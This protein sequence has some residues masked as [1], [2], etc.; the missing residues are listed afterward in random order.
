MSGTLTARRILASCS[1]FSLI[2]AVLIVFPTTSHAAVSDPQPRAEDMVTADALPTVQID[3]IAWAQALVGKT[4]YAG[5]SFANARPAG[6]AP[7]TSLTP[8]AN[9]LSYDLETGLLRT[10]FAPSLNGQVLAVTASPDGSRIYVGGDFTQANGQTRQRIAA[11]ST[12]TGELISSFAPPVNYQVRAI[13]ATDSVVYVGGAFEGVGNQPRRN[14]AAFD[15]ATGALLDWAPQ[16]DRTVWGLALSGDGQTLVASGQF[17]TVNGAAARGLAKID[18]TNGTLQEWPVVISNGGGDAGVT[19][20]SIVDDWVYGTTYHFGPGGNLEGPFKV[21]LTTGETAWVVDCHGDT[22]SQF[23]AENAFYFVGHPH[24]CG[25]V[26]MGFPQYPSWKWQHAMAVSLDATGETLR[27]TLGYHNW[28]GTPSPSIIHWFPTMAAGNKSGASQAAWSVTGND[29]YIVMGGEFPRVNRSPQEGLVRFAVASIAP[30]E[31]APS[32]PDGTLVPSFTPV[33]AG[34]INVSWM[35]GFDPDDR[36]L[37]Y[38][39]VRTPGGTVADFEATSNWWQVPGLNYVDRNLTPGQTYSYQIRVTDGSGNRIFGSTRQIT[40][41][42]Y[43]RNAYSTAVLSHGP[44]LYWPMNEP[45]GSSGV[46]DFAGGS[47]GAVG[48]ATVLGVPGAVSGATAARFANSPGSRIGSAGAVES[49]VDYSVEAWFSS[50]AS[51]GPILGFGDLRTGSSNRVDRQLYLNNGGRVHFG[52]QSNGAKVLATGKP[53]NDGQWHHVVGT[54]SGSTARLYV[55]GVLA[56]KR[57]DIV[58]PEGFVGHWRVG[59]DR[60]SS[61]PSAGAADFSGLIDEV[62]VYE[63]ALTGDEVEQHFVASGRTSNRPARPDDDYGRAVYDLEPVLHWRLGETSGATVLDSGPMANVGTYRG[64]YTLSQPGVSGGD[65]GAVTFDGTT[66]YAASNSSFVNPQVFST[67][68]WFKTTTRRGGKIIGFGNQSTSLS[69]DY[70]RHVYMQNDGRL[71]FGVWPGSEQRITTQRALNDGEWHHLVATLSSDGMK[72]YVDGELAGSN[73]NTGA[74]NYTG[75]WRIGGDR[76]WGGADSGFFSGAIDEVT[77]YA[78]ALA[79]D[80]VREHYL[81]GAQL[82]PPTAAFTVETTDLTVTVDGSSSSDPDGSVS[83]YV[84]DFGDGSTGSGPTAEHTYA[85]AGSYTLRL[86]VTDD[87]GA[88]AMA[89]QEVT[90]THN[91]SPI[92][93]FTSIVNSLNVSLDASSSTDPDGSIAQFYWTFGDGDEGTGVSTSHEYAEAGTYE[94]TLTVIDDG[95]ASD[96][97]TATVTVTAPP[98]NRPPTA[99]AE[100]TINHQLLSV[101]GT[102]SSDPEGSIAAF[103]WDFGDGNGSTDP[104]TQHTY[105]SAGTYTVTLT[106]TDE[107][108]ATDSTSFD[109][110]AVTPPVNQA[111]AAQFDVALDGLGITLDA[112]DSHDPDGQIGEYAWDFGDGSTGSGVAAS[113]AYDTPGSYTVTLTVTDEDGAQASTSQDVTVSAQPP[114]QPPVARFTWTSA[115]LTLTADASTSSDPD[116]SIESYSWDFGDGVQGEGQTAVHT[117]ADAGT[118]DVKL[119]VTDD[120]GESASVTSSITVT[121]P[122]N[123]NE[124]PTASFTTTTTGLSVQVDASTS[125]DADGTIASYLW[126]FGDGDT[127]TGAQAGHTYASAGAYDVTLVVV[128]DDG[129]Q[130]STVKTVEVSATGGQTFALDTFSR[131]LSNGFGTADRGGTWT[132][133]SS[134]SL[135]S[136]AGGTGNIRMQTPGSGPAISLTGMEQ[137]DVAATIDVS[138]DKPPTGGGVYSTLFV[139]RSGAND[140]RLKL[141]TL[142]EGSYLLLA[143]LTN[144]Q[145]VILGSQYLPLSYQPGTEVRMSLSVE[146]EGDSLLAGK[147]WLVGQPE[148]GWQVQVSDSTAANQ[149]AGA[150]GLQSYLSGSSTNAPVMASWDDLTVRS[151]G[152]TPPPNKAPVAGF[153]TVIDGMDLRVDGATSGDV[154]GAV[155]SFAWDFGDGSSGTG[156]T[157]DH[158]YAA[159]GTYDVTLTVTDNEG[160]T[161]SLTRPVTIVGGQEPREI[162][163]DAFQ[164][165]VAQG[166]GTADIGGAWT[167]QARSGSF[168]VADNH[169]RITMTAGAGPRIALESLQGLNTSMVMD[170]G[171]DKAPEGNGVYVTMLGRQDGAQD[172][173]AKVWF[174][175]TSTYIILARQINGS[176]TVLRTAEVPGLVAEPGQMIRLRFDID[177]QGVSD[178]RARAWRASDPEP[179]EWAVTATDS[180]AALQA[181]GAFALQTYLTG[182]APNAPVTALVDQLRITRLGD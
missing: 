26:S 14:L 92:A 98:P 94:V 35:A 115:S 76:V 90:V 172:Y 46:A 82:T 39:V 53:L 70:D 13:A 139:R 181:P 108:G 125:Q 110:V 151:V 150:V 140:Y 130:S 59:G 60:Q 105:S 84:W 64:G 15:A 31:R 11:Y 145:E 34:E 4:V 179:S 123:Q 89:E 137:R 117:Y 113:H 136:A 12:Q 134:S 118:F 2:L 28:A 58:N 19:S 120:S 20:V 153:T 66:G 23:K 144:G 3:G 129:A 61:F 169:G 131:T 83:T 68:A 41:P 147:A 16:A 114:N 42:E 80:Q 25:N 45:A 69:S 97:H 142:P 65:V 157:A 170:I 160:A 27:E 122:P 168:S 127:A 36:S 71:T 77:V 121:E 55:D 99:V 62:A 72:L 86:T 167:P 75:Y 104:A 7:G 8:R 18:A 57:E 165:Q 37:R 146:G 106:V 116:G 10:D 43:V 81:L 73:P 50:T 30:S 109:V 174:R 51:S 164:R 176:E 178:L 128:D 17:E 21:S 78:Q 159:P 48:A 93:D 132:P 96:T 161:G 158:T 166:F 1:L 44:Q 107:A 91:E 156:I 111:P 149:V 67:E 102:G 85:A 119:T 162:A 24:Y 33:G 87:D 63:R 180:A 177:G 163:A 182:S 103:A 155:A 141:R 148:P 49:P 100:H 138:L 74:Q 95:G 143:R 175:P 112:S 56:G 154:D 9:L 38:Q 124:P 22:Y 29:E 133:L 135:F 52:V 5:G 32:F 88:S 40:V 126:D 79:P 152:S 173:R 47:S 6:A 101:D 171:L 54:V